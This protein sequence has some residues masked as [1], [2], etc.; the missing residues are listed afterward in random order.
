MASSDLLGRLGIKIT[1]SNP[2]GSE[3]MAVTDSMG[4][5]TTPLEYTA[6]PRAIFRGPE[7]AGAREKC[8]RSLTEGAQEPA[9]PLFFVHFK[10]PAFL[11]VVTFSTFQSFSAYGGNFITAALGGGKMPT[12]A[13]GD[14]LQFFRH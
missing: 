2:N 3:P 1:H 11:R 6:T 13:W 7:R 8:L 4:T 5:I 14:V 12:T 9:A 10:S